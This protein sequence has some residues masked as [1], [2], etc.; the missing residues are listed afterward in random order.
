MASIS[1]LKNIKARTGTQ[2][3]HS[4]NVMVKDIPIG[5]IRIKA[6]VRQDYTGIEEL[7]ESIRQH[8]LLQ[9]ITV[10]ADGDQYIVKTGHRR[11]LACQKLYETERERFHSIRCIISNAENIAVI[12]LVENVQREDLSQIDL[13]NALSSLREQGVSHKHIAEMMGK[14][15]HYIENLFTAINEIQSNEKLKEHL[16]TAGGSIQNI[17]ET[18]GMLD[19]QARFD[20]LD[21]RQKGNITRAEMRKKAKYLKQDF[22][23]DIPN[24][25]TEALSPEL[26]PSIRILVSDDGLVINLTFNHEASAKMMIA[27]IRRL[28][29]KYGIK[30]EKM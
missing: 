24:N 4:A 10:Y 25:Q 30:E 23:F 18:K 7:A 16:T 21:Q 17:S 2:D 12:Q 1:A 6:N 13:Y 11:F 14:K 8:G 29:G 3:S 20:L 27:G 19:G 5:D 9:P 28:I 26:D 15:L 22:L